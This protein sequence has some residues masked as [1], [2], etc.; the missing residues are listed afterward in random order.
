MSFVWIPDHVWDDKHPSFPRTRESRTAY[1]PDHVGD[2]EGL[3]G[4]EEER[5]SCAATQCAFL[6]CK[7][8]INIM[9]LAGDGTKP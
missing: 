2:D 7:G 4:D 8:N 9:G 1:I 3:V 5:L 6:A